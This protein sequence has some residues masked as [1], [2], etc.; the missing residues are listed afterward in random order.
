[1]TLKIAQRNLLSPALALRRVDADGEYVLAPVIQNA[2][3]A[4]S[5]GTAS[6]DDNKSWKSDRQV[7]KIVN[8]QGVTTLRGTQGSI[9]WPDVREPLV[10]S[11]VMYADFPVNVS[12][13]LHHA[14]MPFTS[15]E[16]NTQTLSAG[17]WNAIYSHE[18]TFGHEG[19]FTADA[20]ITILVDASPNYSVHMSA[21]C[22]TLSRP[23][24]FDQM[25]L[26]G[27]AMLPDVI[28][29]V[30]AESTNPTR[31]VAKFFHSLSA[32]MSRV[33]DTY[34]YMQN[35]SVDEIGH[36]NANIP[37][38]PYY[39]LRRGELF[40][41]EIMPPEYLDYAAMLA[42]TRLLPNIFVNGE[43]IHDTDE[44]DFRRWQASTRSYGHRAGSQGA[45]R[46]AVKT[47]LTGSKFV[48]LTPV[49]N[50]NPFLIGI[51]TLL[52]ETPS[53]AAAGVESAEVLAAAEP[54]RPAG[55]VFSHE[56]VAVI[57]FVLDDAEFGVFNVSTIE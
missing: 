9:A 35:N 16:P 11:A 36:S 53:V 51:K 8:P 29:D 48:I 55:F 7:I 52:S 37:G 12:T 32:D 17:A 13:Y 23:E 25:W 50:G 6:V 49:L 3:K 19:T 42:G 28:H 33:V 2:W 38:S 4:D 21:P 31:P 41:V 40:D 26:N 46:A 20:T 56:S 14:H 27:R 44:F 54:A 24:N 30:D 10:F 1:M 45:I 47:V 18:N 57:P 15:V 5:P 39:R 34:L 43:E 22:L